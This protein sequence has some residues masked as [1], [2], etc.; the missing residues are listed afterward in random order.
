MRALTLTLVL[1]ALLAPTHAAAFC[2]FYVGK[3]DASLY[4][5]AS[6][7]VLVRNANR[8]VLSMMNDYQGDLSEFA[9]V[10][11]VPVVLEKGQIHV[12]DRELFKRIDAYSAPRLVEYFDENPCERGASGRIIPLLDSTVTQN[13]R[14]TTKERA[15]TLGV[16]VDAEYTVGEYDVVILSAKQSN[17]LETWLTENGYHVPAG[18]SRA[19]RPYVQQQ[20]KFFVA[21]VNLTEQKKTRLAYLRPLQFAFES[22]KFMLP[23]RLGMLNADGPQEL[24][25]YVLTENGRVE[26][27]NY[28]TIKSPSG[29]EIPE[30]VKDDFPGFYKAMFDTQVKQ[31]KLRAVFTEYF[32]DMSW[33]DPCAADP[34]SRDELRKF[35]VFWL[36]E[37]ARITPAWILPRQVPSPAATPSV[38]ITRLHV[39][40]SG[41]SFPEDLVLQETADR[42]SFQ[43]RYVLRHPWKGSSDECP[44]ARSYFDELGRRRERAASTLASLTGWRIDEIRKKMALGTMR[45]DDAWWK[46]LWK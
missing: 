6:Q 1:V 41:H 17:G 36:D 25:L 32:W 35:G 29:M 12:G 26:A 46:R 33:C 39:R 4:N 30:Y 11:P 40:Y 3:A 9:L 43:G 37:S 19:L 18:A 24:V 45:N 28:R 8:T 42:A 2:G 23:I 14:K 31:E 21:K 34:L 38:M 15:R 22:P 16:S 5:H 44:A 10:V 27:T 20:M 13:A 7:V